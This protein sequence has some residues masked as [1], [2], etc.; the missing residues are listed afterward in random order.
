[1]R[2]CDHSFDPFDLEVISVIGV[3][4]A[5]RLDSSAIS[6]KTMQRTQ[7]LSMDRRAVAGG[8]EVHVYFGYR[9]CVRA[10]GGLWWIGIANFI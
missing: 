6:F 5:L 7:I 9:Y 3:V 8:L 4:I 1:M 10:K 2:L